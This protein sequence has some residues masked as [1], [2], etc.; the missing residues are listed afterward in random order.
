M[1]LK[2]LE[3]LK[4]KISKITNW[5]RKLPICYVN[6]NHIAGQKKNNLNCSN[7][8]SFK[9]QSASSYFSWK[10]NKNFWNNFFYFKVDTICIYC[11]RTSED[12]ILISYFLTSKIK[13]VSNFINLKMKNLQK[14]ALCDDLFVM[15]WILMII[16]DYINIFHLLC[17]FRKNIKYQP[18]PQYI[19][20]IYSKIA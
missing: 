17:I 5:N 11:K 4:W 16:R 18:I 6:F 3:K 19:V 9:F 14:C 15:W 8:I 1:E 7:F 20:Q 2:Y 12:F 10:I 13:F